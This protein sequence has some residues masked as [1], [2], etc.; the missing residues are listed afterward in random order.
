MLAE[1]ARQLGF[2]IDV[3]T[4]AT[5]IPR[6]VDGY[7]VVMAMG[8][9]PS[10]NDEVIGPWFDDELALLRDADERG[11][12]V[13]GICFGA[14]ALAVALGGTVSRSPHPE[15]GWYPVSS[16]APDLIGPGPWFEWH[17]DAITPPPGA[18]ILA[19][20]DVAVQAYTV[21]NHLAVQFHPEVT[22]NEIRQWVAADP[23]T[24]RRLHIDAD[25]LMAQTTALLPDARRRAY[26]LFDDFL[27]H[28][29]VTVTG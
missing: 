16:V 19:T 29:G 10:V 27:V 23:D 22:G 6:R 26:R 3:A 4:P 20:T 21:R 15:V 9:S 14:Q 17:F 5:G 2:V 12:A 18:E 1:R 24:L 7:V 13:F 11:V 25:A 28:A 8:A